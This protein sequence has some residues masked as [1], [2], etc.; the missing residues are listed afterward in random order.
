MPPFITHNGQT[1]YFQNGVFMPMSRQQ[2]DMQFGN[3]PFVAAQQPYTQQQ[4]IPQ[5][6]IQPPMAG[7]LSNE[8]KISLKQGDA[9]TTDAVNKPIVQN[10]QSVNNAS[11]N[12]NP[13]IQPMQDFGSIMAGQMYKFNN[14]N[15]TA[16]SQVQKRINNISQPAP[17]SELLQSATN[18]AQNVTTNSLQNTTSGV[19][20][21]AATN[22]ATSNATTVTDPILQNMGNGQAGFFQDQMQNASNAAANAT[23]A[24]SDGLDGL[25]FS[26]KWKFSAKQ[27][28]SNSKDF[29]GSEAGQATSMGI[30]AGL[31]IATSLAARNASVY[32]QR[33]GMS[34]PNALGTIASDSTVTQI[35]LNPL[36]MGATGGLSAVAGLTIDAIKNS[37]KYAKQKDKY[38][39]KKLA[40][41]TMQ[42]LDDARENMKPDYTG[43]ARN[44][45]QVNPY[46]KAQYG[47]EVIVDKKKMNTDSKEYREMYASG[48]LMRVDEGGMPT[49]TTEE[50]V[51]TA[52]A[53]EHLK[54][55]R[56][57]DYLNSEEGERWMYSGKKPKHEEGYS[58]PLGEREKIYNSIVPAGY[59]STEILPGI[60]RYLT[61]TKRNF[62]E[63]NTDTNRPITSKDDDA[64]AFFMGMPQK[65]N[66]ITE[67]KYRP[68]NEKNINSKYYTLKNAYK[69]LH[70]DDFETHIF[71]VA[72]NLFDDEYRN[73]INN[74]LSQKSSIIRRRNSNM[75]GVKTNENT[76]TGAKSYISPL[77]HA[78]FTKGS[79]DRG[80]Y[81]SIYDIYDFNIP[82]Q[83][84]IGKPYEIYDRVYYKNYNGKN[85]PM[86]YTDNELNTIKLNYD[87]F[88]SIYKELNNRNLIDSNFNVYKDDERYNATLKALDKYKSISKI[89]QQ[90]RLGGMVQNPYIKAQYGTKVIVDGKKINT[91]SRQYREMYNS[92]NLMRVDKDGIP[93]RWSEEDVVVTAP[94]TEEERN[95]RKWNGGAGT[96]QPPTASIQSTVPT[97]TFYTDP[98]VPY[99]KLRPEHVNF[100]QETEEGKKNEAVFRAKETMDAIKSTPEYKH[101]LWNAI[102]KSRGFL[103]NDEKRG[104]SDYM[105]V[106]GSSRFDMFGIVDNPYLNK[107]KQS[108]YN[109]QFKNPHGLYYDLENQRNQNVD[110]SDVGVLSQRES[111]LQG[112]YGYMKRHKIEDEYDKNRLPEYSFLKEIMMVNDPSM[113]ENVATAVEEIEH[114]QQYRPYKI[115]NGD[116]FKPYRS[117]YE[118]DPGAMHNITPFEAEVVKKYNTSYDPYLRLPYETAAK[119]RAAEVFFIQNKMLKPGQKM[120]QEHYYYLQKEY[121]KSVNGEKT[122]VPTNVLQ[123]FELSQPTSKQYSKSWDEYMKDAK[124]EGLPLELNLEMIDNE[125]NQTKAIQNFRNKQAHNFIM[126]SKLLAKNNKNPST[127]EPI[128]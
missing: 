33:V 46:L 32:D 71:N 21:N 124:K 114:W 121:E 63:N 4:A 54:E 66:T 93:I 92:G 14:P 127:N 36:L 20:A 39:N 26:G 107:N 79:D 58:L 28:F 7:P 48:N 42:S 69:D 117:P 72:N 102:E 78:T 91:D 125:K 61:G 23:Q 95:R 77:E 108:L 44:G 45:T 6:V 73:D 47:T 128:S 18:A 24:T 104:L 51:V 100:D 60:Y 35:G 89:N 68:Q 112:V 94:M 123:Y 13:Y 115:F 59:P 31:G 98:S 109:Y 53:P 17:E 110:Y 96:Y 22:A 106:D 70:D 34:K 10:N 65:N 3:N 122:F 37:I 30:G 15:F 86:Y 67:S 84:S 50:V 76:V 5:G 62:A 27:A 81:Y 97:G 101:T 80:N 12:N 8:Q 83:E 99:A 88:N 56:A 74:K 16:Q 1:G 118:N 9:T 52:E 116:I 19:L 126:L 41:D 55:K 38:E 57:M 103:D 105:M 85:K 43:Y 29:F 111:D 25:G 113:D 49:M 64:W 75:L 87:N 2:Y 120:G 82:M 40:V 90:H 11:V 119:K